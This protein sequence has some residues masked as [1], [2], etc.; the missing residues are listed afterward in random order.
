[1]KLIRQADY[2]RMPWKNGLGFTEEIAIGPQGAKFP[3]DPFDWRL[4]TA[5]VSDPGPFSVFQH[6]DRW[7]TVIEGNG[8]T[9]NDLPLRYGECVHLSGEAPVHG[10]PID[11]SVKDLGL[12]F[13]RRACN[14][15]MKFVEAN[16]GSLIVDCDA[17]K[18]CFLY[19]CRGKL[20]IGSTS[21]FAG[22]TLSLEANDATKLLCVEKAEF[23][24][25]K[26]SSLLDTVATT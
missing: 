17:D 20:A 23:V 22:E 3:N 21:M 11:G 8:L 10:K 25:V 4:S 15:E 2:K 13:A 26:I 1:V 7:L 6:C 19:L 18:S 12:I 9:L 14:A 16:I 5:T 24:L